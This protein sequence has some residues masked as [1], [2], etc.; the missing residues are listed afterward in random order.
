MSNEIRNGG[1]GVSPVRQSA[2]ARLLI[3]LAVAIGISVSLA[4]SALASD[5]ETVLYT[6]SG[7][8]DGT[9]PQARLLA[10]AARNLYGVTYEGG[11]YGGGTVFELTPQGG[12]A[13]TL[14]TLY[15]FRGGAFDGAG[16]MG[17]LVMDPAGNLYGTTA[18]GGFSEEGTIYELTPDGKGSWTETVLRSTER[19]PIGGLALDAAGNLYGAVGSGGVFS[20]PLCGSIYELSR[21]AKGAKKW[22][23]AG[24]HRFRGTKYGD[25]AA[26]NGD[27]VLDAAGN[28][29]GTTEEGGGN[30]GQYGTVFELSPGAGG[31][32]EKVLYSFGKSPDGFSPQAGL[33]FDSAGNLYGTTND[34]GEDNFGTVFELSPSR[35]GWTETVLHGFTGGAD[36]EY[37]WAPV[38]FRRG[39]LYGTVPFGGNSGYGIVFELSPSG[40]TW[41]ENILYTF[42]NGSDGEEP[43]GAVILDAAGNLYGNAY[44]GALGYGIVYEISP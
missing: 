26:P 14:T 40:G 36:G 43:S 7:G 3:A 22:K 4:A 11:A 34:G 32:T 8:A 1:T 38:T 13:W 42:M 12:G 18:G 31:W 23:Y 27:L 33:I 10:D 37:P 25:G 19:S 15:S 39:N 2:L 28:L 35:G 16:P 24:L 21:L 20:C 41:T 9:Y 17:A 6:F 29:Y 30:S 5:V 44:G